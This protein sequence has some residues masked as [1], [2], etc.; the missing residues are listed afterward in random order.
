MCV[1]VFWLWLQV[2]IARAAPLAVSAGSSHSASCACA[3]VDSSVPL[4]YDVLLYSA[5]PPAKLSGEVYGL[6]DDVRVKCKFEISNSLVPGVSFDATLL[7]DDGAMS[8]LTLPA[9]KVIQLGLQPVGKLTKTKGSNNQRDLV[10]TLAPQVL[11]KGTFIRDGQSEEV[12]A[13]LE[14]KVHK[15][16]YDAELAK[17]GAGTVAGSAPVAAAAAAAAAAP[18]PL[19]GQKRAA[20]AA[21]AAASPASKKQHMA[22]GNA[23]TAV[24]SPSTPPPATAALPPIKLSPVRH[25]GDLQREDRVVIGARGAFKL[26]FK[27][28]V[29]DCC[30]ELE[31]VELDED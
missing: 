14:C 17:G 19:S 27:V 18:S 28:N 13:L 4:C 8:E 15:T 22:A 25:R 12:E 31:E 26:G 1:C 21:A 20:P 2:S 16:E 5:R 10:Y 23:A 6:Q 29:K 9:R 24:A 3:Q 30:L 11:V 7:I